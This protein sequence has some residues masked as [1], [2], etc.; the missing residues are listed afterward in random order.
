[1]PTASQSTEPLGLFSE[2]PRPRLYDRVIEVLP[3]T[4]TAAE[5]NAPTSAGLAGLSSFIV[6][7]IRANSPHSGDSSRDCA[8]EQE[9]LTE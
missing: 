9:F 7:A 6:P 2:K 5:P 1:M 8:N 3:S 4:T